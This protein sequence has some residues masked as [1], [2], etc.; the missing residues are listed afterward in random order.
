[1]AVCISEGSVDILY[2]LHT[3]STAQS[4]SNFIDILL[5]VHKH[6]CKTQKEGKVTW[7]TLTDGTFPSY[8]DFENTLISH[9]IKTTDRSSE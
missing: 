9:S 2:P 7:K 4:H 1:M 6:I 8:H 5:P 3:L